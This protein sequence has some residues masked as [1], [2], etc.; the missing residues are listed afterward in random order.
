MFF[1]KRGLGESVATYRTKHAA[2]TSLRKEL[3][4][5]RLMCFFIQLNAI[6]IAGRLDDDDP[7][8]LRDAVALP[9]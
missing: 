1:P 5:Y 7:T 8:F 4:V 3:G 2:K 6:V 9:Q